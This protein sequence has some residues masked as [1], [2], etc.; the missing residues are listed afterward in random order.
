M[1]TPDLANMRN[2][3]MDREW[4]NATRGIFCACQSKPALTS[5]D[6]LVLVFAIELA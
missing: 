5:D 3:D 1:T 2:D 4:D 6:E